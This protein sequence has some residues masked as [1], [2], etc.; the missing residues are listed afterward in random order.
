LPWATNPSAVDLYLGRNT[1]IHRLDPRAK[2]LGLSAAFVLA[3]AFN[4][5]AF[6][7]G[8][9]LA[10][11][12]LALLARCLANL[13]RL[14]A[15]LLAL[16]VFSSVLWPLMLRG[17]T[18]IARIGPLLLTRES[19]LFGIAVGLRLDAIV[20]AGL[21]FL[22]TTRVEEFTA[23]LR[24]LGLPF[25]VGFAFSLAFRFVPTFI[26]SAYAIIQAQRSRGLDLEHGGPLTRVRRHVPLLIPA[27]VGAIRNTDLLA[28]ALESRGFGGST[29]RSDYLEMRMRWQDV[30]VCLL[31]AGAAAAAVWMRLSGHGAVLPRL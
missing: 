22:S 21:I 12:F 25:P 9:A 7:A 13:W 14:R 15:I 23:G 28:M 4:H 19:V 29:P 27:I 6:V 8:V 1:A 17:P 16:L 24:R 20:V 3:L 2:I 5:P 30:A 26:D 31:L 18:E 10:V 11:V